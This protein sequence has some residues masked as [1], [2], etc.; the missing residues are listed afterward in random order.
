MMPN[1]RVLSHRDL[2]LYDTQGFLLIPGVLSRAEVEDLLNPFDQ[3][4]PSIWQEFSQANRWT[5]LTTLDPRFERLSTDRRL[6]DCAFD[7]VNQPMRLIESYGLRYEPGGSFFMHSGNVQNTVY[8]D[9]THSTINLAYRCFYHDQ[10]IY[11]SLVKTLV[12]LT[13]INTEKEGAFCF[14]HG[15]HKA[16][17]PFPWAEVE[18]SNDRSLSETSFPGLGVVF[19][20]AGDVLLLNE[21]LCHGATRTNKSRCLLSFLYGP[22]F[23]PDFERLQPKPNDLKSVGFYD[24]DYESAGSGFICGCEKQPSP[25]LPTLLQ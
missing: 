14:V 15:S 20:K 9:G 12:Y 24:A 19:P 22:A 1:T 13:D 6:V 18:L 5:H 10:R 7:V 2:Y 11:T 16:N 23:M 21:A 17:F 8:S 25:D 4:K 3:M